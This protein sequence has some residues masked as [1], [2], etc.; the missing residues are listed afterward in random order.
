MQATTQERQALAAA[1]APLGRRA[2]GRDWASAWLF[3]APLHRRHGRA[4]R[5]PVRRAIVLSLQHKMVGRRR[6]RGSGSSNY[7]RAALGRDQYAPIFR[8]SVSVSLVYTVVAIVAK[9]VLGMAHGAAAEREFRGRSSCAALLFLPWAMPTL[10]AALTW[11]WIYDGTPSGLL[12]LIR[13][14]YLPTRRR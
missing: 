10:I 12:N 6:R 4:D 3:L 2:L 9:L 7:A 14:D 11:R 8:H 1:R 13:I 5:L